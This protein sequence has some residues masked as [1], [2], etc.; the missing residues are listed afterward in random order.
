MR[1]SIKDQALM[2]FHR[3]Q[4]GLLSPRTTD[5]CPNYI[6]ITKIPIKTCSVEDRNHLSGLGNLEEEKSDFFGGGGYRRTAAVPVF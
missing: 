3:L 6:N 2:T 5:R 4:I 1:S